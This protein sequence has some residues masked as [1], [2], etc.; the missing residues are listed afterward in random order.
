MGAALGAALGVAASLLTLT[1]AAVAQTPATAPAS[2]VG[3]P[4]GR[5]WRVGVVPQRPPSQIAADWTPVLREVGQRS[6]Q[7][8]TLVVLP[9]IPAFEQQLRG[10]SLDFAY[11]N[12]YHQLL[13]HRWQGFQPLVRDRTLLEGLLVVP[14]TSPLRTIRELQGA[15]VAF[16]AQNAFAASLLI[17][18]LLARESIRITPTYLGNHSNVYRS[19]ALQRTP[20]GGGVNHTLE[21][22]RPELRDQLRVLWVTPGFPGHPFSASGDVPTPVRARVQ[23]AFLML[24]RSP[25]G[26]RL[27]Q[28]VNL[29]RPVRASQSRDYAPLG[30]LGLERFATQD[31]G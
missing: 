3:D 28:E 21:E 23:D 24:A 9:T 29:D 31:G 5:H 25:A 19:V 17:R 13:A 12:P 18:S 7:C 2:C 6:G 15:T 27:L 4:L 11:L 20:A 14:R 16:P 8:F 1:A 26:R 10:G 30:R 22:E